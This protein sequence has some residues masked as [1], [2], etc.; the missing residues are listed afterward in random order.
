MIEQNYLKLV[1]TAHELAKMLVKYHLA[2]KY[3]GGQPHL[4]GSPSCA[5]SIGNIKAMLE[6]YKSMWSK[7]VDTVFTSVPEGLRTILKIET[8]LRVEVHVVKNENT[9]LA[10][11]KGFEA[12]VALY[13]HF[14]KMLA[15]LFPA[16][17]PE[18]RLE[19]VKVTQ[20]AY[21]EVNWTPPPLQLWFVSSES[22]RLLVVAHGEDTAR[23]LFYSLTG[24]MLGVQ[25][26]TRLMGVVSQYVSEEIHR[27]APGLAS[28]DAI[29]S[30]GG[31]ITEGFDG[32]TRRTSVFNRELVQET[33]YGEKLPSG[34]ATVSNI[35]K[36]VMSVPSDATA[37]ASPKNLKDLN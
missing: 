33:L 25:V 9:L 3:S 10:P 29:W 35:L 19:G 18:Q 16:V 27:Y 4:C 15:P 5:E 6:V 37:P 31:E 20:S 34:N 30:A 13:P 1:A 7:A 36:S 22:E 12:A 23:L 21:S 8:Q 17:H 14:P 11:F 26:H 28:N 32:T 24:A 2:E